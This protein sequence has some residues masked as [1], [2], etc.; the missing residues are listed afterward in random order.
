MPGFILGLSADLL[1]TGTRYCLDAETSQLVDSE[2]RSSPMLQL[3]VWAQV[4]IHNFAYGR[5]QQIFAL[6][7]TDDG[8]AYLVYD[9]RSNFVLQLEIRLPV[10]T[11]LPN[12]DPCYQFSA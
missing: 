11:Q 10:C 6:E 9:G 7:A 4:Q 3:G 12:G 8:E 1:A 5:M 2:G